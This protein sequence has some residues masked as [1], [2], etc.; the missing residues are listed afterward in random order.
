MKMH[1]H[2]SHAS[3]SSG[4]P[5]EP[6]PQIAVPS[7]P[8]PSS[9]IV[10]AATGNRLNFD[11]LCWHV[12]P[13]DARPSA[14][15]PHRDRQPDDAPSTFR[16][17]GTAMYATA[18][19]PFTDA[20]PE[21]S[22]L[23]VI[24][25]QHDPGY[26][27]GDDDDP[28]ADKDP[29]Q[30]CLPDKEAYQHIT[31]VP[32]EAGSAVVFT[33]RIIHWGSRGR[34][35][36]KGYDTSAAATAS[37][38]PPLKPV[39]PRVCVSFG[40]ADDAYEPAYVARS[41][42]LP[43]PPLAH[44][45]ALV[46]AQCIV[47]HE[48]FP[49]SVRMLRLMHDAVTSVGAEGLFDSAYKKKVMYEYVQAAAAVAAAAGRREGAKRQNGA[50]ALSVSDRGGRKTDA[51]AA[52]SSGRPNAGTPN[53]S[54][55]NPF[56]MAED[57]A[58]EEEA[59]EAAEEE[60]EDDEDER[61]ALMERTLDWMVDA[62]LRGDGDDFDDDFDDYEDGVLEDEDGVS[63][64]DRVDGGSHKRKKSGGGVRGFGGGGKKRRR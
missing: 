61:E 37:T 9:D 14:F 64:V 30:L 2:A 6:P 42:N 1:A 34:G 25:R 57:S 17:D 16:A 3:A 23:Y 12:D 54:K 35:R 22:C 44:R 41:S 46:S 39:E 11:A 51:N 40:F 8:C 29:L 56:E 38:A 15:S 20:T 45:A 4:K 27:V 50:N 36:P 7:R 21:N 49:P 63:L 33:H 60:C 28:G 19:V 13:A 58:G 31:A 24:P 53:A 32:A 55:R 43:F 5:H 59:S 52:G 48:R 18:W 10:L 26:F 47:Y 62:K